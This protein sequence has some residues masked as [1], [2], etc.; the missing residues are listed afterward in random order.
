MLECVICGREFPIELRIDGRRCNFRG[1]KHCLDCHPYRPL[2]GPRK[3]VPRATKSLVCVACGRQFLA[4]M[5]IDGKMRSLYRRRFCLECSPFGEHNTSK[6]P[7]GPRSK[8]EAARARRDR[9]REQFRRSLRKRRRKRKLD[10]VSAYGGRCVDCGYATCPEALQFHHRDPSTKEF[11][12]G[13]FSGSLARLIKEAAK[14]DL[15]MRE[16]SPSPPRTR[17]C[18]IRA[19]D[20]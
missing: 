3:P 13:K 1:R 14:C 20:S 15:G 7:L 6:V 10:L 12:L 8:E 9:R 19:S 4:K 5:V 18:R 11:G 17:G 16:L 2:K